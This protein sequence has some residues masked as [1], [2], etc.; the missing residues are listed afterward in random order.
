[1]GSVVI[2]M[3]AARMAWDGGTTSRELY[4][5]APRSPILEAAVMIFRRMFYMGSRAVVLM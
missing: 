5:S 2:T 3:V 4:A 1:M